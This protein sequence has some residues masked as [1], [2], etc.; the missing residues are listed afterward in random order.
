MTKAARASDADG[1]VGA[2]TAIHN[3]RHR[4]N[5]EESTCLVAF[6]SSPSPCLLTTKTAHVNSGVLLFSLNRVRE[7][8]RTGPRGTQRVQAGART[9]HRD[10]VPRGGAVSETRCNRGWRR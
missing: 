2:N 9:G 1:T 8:S 4:G 7:V 6:T 10:C 5:E 3:A